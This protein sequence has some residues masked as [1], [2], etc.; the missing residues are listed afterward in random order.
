MAQEYKLKG[1]NSLALQP[2]EKQE[3]EVE[4]LGAKVLLLNAGGTVQAVGPRCTHYGAPLAK[5]IL[6]TNGKLTCPWHGACFNAKTGDVEDAPALN[7]L[8]VFRATERDG[9]VYITGDPE[10]IKRGHRAPL[11][12]CSAA[13]GDKILVVGGGSGALGI[14]EGLRGGG[15]QGG[16]TLISNEGY[17]PIDRPKLSKALMTDLAKLQWR[18]D[19]WYKDASVDF[20]QDEVTEVDFATKTVTTK[21]GGKFSYTKLVLSTGGTPRVLPA[22]GFKVLGNIFT[23]RNV[24]DAK[25]IVD[26][27]GDKGKKIVIVGSSFIGMEIAVATANG[28]DVT[29]VGMEKAPLERVLGEKVGNII[30]KGVEAKGV[31]FYLSGG[32]EKAESSASNPSTVGFVHLKD[33]TKLEAD[34]VIL[35]VGVAPATE[36]LKNNSVVRLEPDGSLKVD[37]TYSVVGLKD[38]YALGDIATHPYRGPGGEGKYVRIE[39]WNVAQ[40]AGRTAASHILSPNRTPEFY[41][42]VFWSALGSQ[43]RYCGNTMASGWDDLV[44]QGDPDQGKWVAYYAKGETIV[45]MASMGMDP[46]MAQCA[47]LM[48][49]NRMPC[50]TQLQGGLDILSIG[51]P[52][53][54]HNCAG[55]DREQM[56]TESMKSHETT[57]SIPGVLYSS[58][59]FLIVIPVLIVAIYHLLFHPLARI[60]GPR[61]AA[62][63]NIWQGL[64]VR[65]GRIHELAKTLHGEYG[66]VVRVGPNEVWFN[67]REAFK[68]IYCHRYK[69]S[70][71]YLATALNRPIVDWRLNTHFPDTLDFL[72]EFDVARYRVQRRLI[73]PIYS[74]SHLRNF[75]PAIDGVVKAVISALTALD[76]AEVDL[77]EWM[78]IIAVECLGA[79]VLSWS[80]GYIKNRSDGGTSA[81]GYLGW[82]RKSIFGL[83]PTVTALSFSFKTLGRVFSNVW[84]VTFKTPKNFKPFFTP[85][86][87]K[88]S[89]RIV[90]ALHRPVQPGLKADDRKDLLADLIHLH[91][92]RPEFTE[93]YLRRLAVTNFGAGHETM[94][95]ALTAIMA[96]IGSHSEVH[97][98]VAEEVR[99][100]SHS[101]TY[102][103]VVGLRY[104]QASMREAQRLHPVIAMALPRSVPHDG[105]HLHGHFFPTNTVVGCNPVA[106]HRNPD[107]FGAD[108]DRYNPLR[109][110][111]GD[112]D[113]RIRMM[114]RTHLIWGGGARTCPGRHLA[115]LVLS[116]VVPMLLK[117]FDV[118]ITAMPAEKDMP[119]YFLAMMTGV[120]ARFRPVA[121]KGSET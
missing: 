38:V 30:K 45:A 58:T 78:H 94:C 62:L 36:Y 9:A 89:R 69:K 70:D 44:L 121:A 25:R 74:T 21:S 55:D 114:E 42:P 13:G 53:R 56:Q 99:R 93:T 73:G 104:T 63:S 91:K 76:G 22:Q 50:K 59:V 14:I 90:N 48:S 32:V 84:G 115:D 80:P 27:I 120:K 113:A 72:S 57:S 79:V 31:K 11:F 51:P 23:L 112:D 116:K 43:L 29:V 67:S 107:I 111:S 95:S 97:C 4:G 17:L 61:L 117:E 2:G 65:E 100:I 6:G 15:Y 68:Q 96:M 77:K 37:E 60:P 1:V 46:A 54:S 86:Y 40:N 118:E 8:P 52:H 24:H 34:L 7:A 102:D 92:S 35:G 87:Q 5:G 41:T 26:A 109:W 18:D 12:K 49:L 98:K 16:I 47:Q 75:E 20:V 3:V 39:H 66:P 105:M 64:H 110:L 103:D 83:F 71:F 119:C 10:T 85:I 101:L 81:Q 33:G 19:G 82:K 108:A 28:N 88:T 106:L